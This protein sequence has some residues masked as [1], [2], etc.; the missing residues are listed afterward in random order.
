M[1][2]LLAVFVLAWSMGS[3]WGCGFD[4]LHGVDAEQADPGDS[5]HAGDLD[6]PGDSDHAGDLDDLPIGVCGRS[7][8][9]VSI[10][11]YRIRAVLGD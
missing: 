4:K 6:D 1:N 9:R 3:S 10:V 8:S 5:D 11:D 7:V 2:R